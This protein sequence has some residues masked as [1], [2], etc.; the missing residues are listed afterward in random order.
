MLALPAFLLLCAPTSLGFRW[1]VAS[2]ALA[3]DLFAMLLVTASLLV[4][5]CCAILSDVG[6]TALAR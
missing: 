5:T 6:I 2:I 4:A 3:G 1:D